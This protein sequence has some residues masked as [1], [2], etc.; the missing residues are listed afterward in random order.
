M[1]RCD[2]RWSADEVNSRRLWKHDGLN[3]YLTL[4]RDSFWANPALEA[5]LSW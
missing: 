5:I 4:L 3:F 1:L 2:E